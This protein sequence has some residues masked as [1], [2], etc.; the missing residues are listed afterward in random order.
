[1]ETNPCLYGKS[2]KGNPFAD[3]FTDP[4]CN[5]NLKETSEFVKSLPMAAEIKRNGYVDISAQRR[6][7]AGVNSITAMQR[8]SMEAPST[9]GRPV[10]SFSSS[11]PAR[12]SFPSKWDDAQ[13]WLIN[14]TNS[15][16]E[17]SALVIKPAEFS[18]MPKQCVVFKQ[19][20]EVIAEKSRVTE[21]KVSEVV[22]SFQGSLSLEDHHGDTPFHGVSGSTDFLLKG[23]VLISHDVLLNSDLLAVLEFCPFCSTLNHHHCDLFC[24]FSSCNVRSYWILFPLSALY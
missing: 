5:L 7:E 12:K 21:E 22:S 10:F 8:R 24:F 4:L 2:N 20:M 9:P 3:T 18:K 14:G 11:D 16:H 23:Q 17:S 6:R 15:C 13:K 19:Q 1:M